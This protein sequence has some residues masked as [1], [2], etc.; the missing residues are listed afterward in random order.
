MNEDWKR[1]RTEVEGRHHVFFSQAALVVNDP[2]DNGAEH[3]S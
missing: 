2:K 1:Q 3:H